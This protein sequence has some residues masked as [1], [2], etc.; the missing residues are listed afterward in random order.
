LQFRRGLQKI[1]DE[2][3]TFDKFVNIKLNLKKCELFNFLGRSTNKIT[4]RGEEKD[5][6]TDLK[7]VKYIGILI[8]SRRKGK[9]KFAEANVQ[10]ILIE[11]D[12]SEF[13]DLAI[14]QLLKTIKIMIFIRLNYLFA[15]RFILKSRVKNINKRIRKLIYNFSEDKTISKSYI[16]A[17]LNFSDLGIAET[18]IEMRTYRIHH[19]S[20]LLL[21]KEELFIMNEYRNLQNKKTSK[22]L[23][24]SHLLKLS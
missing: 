13:K 20:R 10:K 9:V 12:K 3:E 4:I 2:V 14:N 8:N 6:I 18:L 17:L 11:I 19:V 5:Y 23:S 21:K 22:F 7:F 1:I 24:S 15:N 16:Y